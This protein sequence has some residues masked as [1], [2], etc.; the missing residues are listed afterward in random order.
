MSSDT[1][2]YSD[3]EESYVPP[4]R[5]KPMPPTSSRSKVFPYS[6]MT[7]DGKEIWL[8]KVPKSMQKSLPSRIPLPEAWKPEVRFTHDGTHYAVAENKEEEA[9]ASKIKLLCPGA[10]GALRQVPGKFSKVL[11]INE[12]ADIPTIKS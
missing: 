7:S 11:Q 10:D 1:E 12:V 5:F 8:F 3:S 2:S 4:D 9:T 6:K